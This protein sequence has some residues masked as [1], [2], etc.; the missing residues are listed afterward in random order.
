[1]PCCNLCPEYKNILNQEPRVTPKCP[2]YVSKE[3]PWPQKS[4]PSD[5]APPIWYLL[6]VSAKCC[7]NCPYFRAEDAQK[8]WWCQRPLA[9]EVKP[10]N[11]AEAIK[12]SGRSVVPRP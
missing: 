1:M 10:D 5:E 3:K 8:F 2:G 7:P 12:I 6:K 11:A 4:F 9:F